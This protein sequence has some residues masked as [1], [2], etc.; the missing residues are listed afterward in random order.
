MSN[1][2]GLLDE[3]ELDEITPEQAER[4]FARLEKEIFEDFGIRAEEIHVALRAG[5]LPETDAVEE[6]IALAS[7]GFPFKPGGVT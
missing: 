4:E 5:S 3:L 1:I 2:E 6:W 7:M